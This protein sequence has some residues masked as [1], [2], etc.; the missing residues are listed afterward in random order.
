MVHILIA[1]PDKDPLLEFSTGFNKSNDVEFTWAMK[2]EE[3]ISKINQNKFDLLLV[4]EMLSDITGIECLN[5]VVLE[6]P[7]LNTAAISSLSAK[8][9]HEATEG[10]GVLMQIPVNPGAEDGEKLFDYLNNILKM[11]N[12]DLKKRINR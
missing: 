1:T 8:D 12:P 7:F 11:T 3:V 6:N 4:D 9:Y 5:K 2:C 10:L